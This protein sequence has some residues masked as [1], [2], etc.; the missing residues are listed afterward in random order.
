MLPLRIISAISG[1]RGRLFPKKL[2]S[3]S[4]HSWLTPPVELARTLFDNVVSRH[5]SLAELYC[6]HRDRMAAFQFFQEFCVFAG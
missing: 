6:R 2:V 4:V 3:I 1:I 5:K